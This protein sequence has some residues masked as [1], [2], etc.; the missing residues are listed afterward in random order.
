[1]LERPVL[2]NLF[3]E[4]VPWAMLGL[5]ALTTVTSSLLSLSGQGDLSFL[6][7]QYR[8]NLPPE[9]RSI[10]SVPLFKSALKSNLMN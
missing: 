4:I 9:I 6:E 2:L 3:T 10:K 1:M 5:G 7:H 8:S